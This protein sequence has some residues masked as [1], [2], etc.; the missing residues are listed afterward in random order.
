MSCLCSQS[1]AA[2]VAR[3]FPSQACVAG[4]TL[5]ASDR[6]TVANVSPAGADATVRGK[7]SRSV[8]LRSRGDALMVSCT[9]WPTSIDVG[10][11]K[12]VWAAL[13]AIDRS[14]GLERLREGSRPLAL[15]PIP[16]ERAPPRPGPKKGRGPER[17]AKKT[18][19]APG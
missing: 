8:R 16:D 9:C 17:S 3:H 19:R 5:L 15:A 7:R 4:F 11:C 6:V 12:H 18:P 13:L 10:A 14:G 2:R 1:L